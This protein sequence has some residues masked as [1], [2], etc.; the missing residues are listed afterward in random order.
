MLNF[1]TA[2]IIKASFFYRVMN[3]HGS[4]S[5]VAQ[6]HESY[7]FERRAVM[8]SAILR[9]E[10]RQLKNFAV[11]LSYE[12]VGIFAVRRGPPILADVV[13]AIS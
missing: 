8:N 3:L 10:A 6:L 1:R 11:L 13:K 5:L 9:N 2:A 4:L 7:L 12:T